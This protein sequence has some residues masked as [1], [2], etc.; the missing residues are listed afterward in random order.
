MYQQYQLYNYALSIGRHIHPI[1][2]ENLRT[3][4]SAESSC[5]VGD[6]FYA[7]CTADGFSCYNG[8]KSVKTGINTE[9][10]DIICY[11]QNTVSHE[12]VIE[13]GSFRPFIWYF[14]KILLSRRINPQFEFKSFMSLNV[15]RDIFWSSLCVVLT[16]WYQ[17]YHENTSVLV[18]E[19]ASHFPI[20]SSIL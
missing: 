11:V 1:F 7:H 6:G 8:N 17:L 18:C 10:T 19:Y 15:L 2:R 16:G 4:W 5:F 13:S 14:A 12:F 9:W 20:V 3:T